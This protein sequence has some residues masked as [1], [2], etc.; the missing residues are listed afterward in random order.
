M[1]PKVWFLVPVLICL[2]PGQ[3]Q[4]RS[5]NKVAPTVFTGKVVAIDCHAVRIDCRTL[6]RVGKIDTGDSQC[7]RSY[8]QEATCVRQDGMTHRKF[9]G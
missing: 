9:R 5:E 2:V 6:R 7:V 3:Y 1:N 8:G 4:A